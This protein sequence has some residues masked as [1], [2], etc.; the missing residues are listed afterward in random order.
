MATMPRKSGRVQC[1]RMPIPWRTHGPC[2]IIGRCYT[3]RETSVSK[4]RATVREEVATGVAARGGPRMR[5]LTG[6]ASRRRAGEAGQTTA[7][8]AM[9][10]G[11]L[12]ALGVFIGSVVPEVLGTVI[13]A[14][15]LSV[16]TIAP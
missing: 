6:P 9:I 4:G 1:Q 15:A 7:E 8:W 2:R 16:R 12:A 13:R 3:R 5:R 11:F 14:L 10:A